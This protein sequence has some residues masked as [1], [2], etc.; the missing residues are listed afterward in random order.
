MRKTPRSGRPSH[1]RQI[2]LRTTLTEGALLL[3]LAVLLFNTNRFFTFI[4]DETNI[5]GPAA[6]PTAVFFSSLGTLLRSHEH[7]PLYDV[8]LHFW[9]RLTGGAMD[10][11]RVPSVVFFIAGLFC[12][13]RA[14]RILAG[15]PASTA[16]I[17]LGVLWPY[18]FHFGRL[19]GWYSF[20]FF[21]IAALTWAYLRH[22]A[23][24]VENRDPAA[25][26][27]AWVRV[28]LLGLAL[29]YANY[30]GW[31]LLFLLSV[32]DWIRHRTRPD[33][34]KRLLDHRRDFDCGLRAAVARAVAGIRRRYRTSPVMDL[35]PDQRRL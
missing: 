20:A 24:L 3:L 21:L 25:C 30:L 19:A 7:P 33:T 26:R 29:V 18:G 12:L 4:D 1:A 15:N 34:V 17:W 35:S 32:D 9:L 27:S 2:R 5:L 14:A 28:C 16:L 13:S 31:A 22:A 11:L 6:Q 10:W 23:L 8:I